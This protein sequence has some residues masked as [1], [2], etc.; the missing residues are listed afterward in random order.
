MIQ[1]LHSIW[2]YS[3]LQIGRYYYWIDRIEG[4]E[5]NEHYNYDNLHCYHLGKFVGVCKVHHND[6]P[7]FIM[8]NE[9]NSLA[10]TIWDLYSNRPRYI[11]DAME[12][13]SV[14]GVDDFISRQPE[15]L[16]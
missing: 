4:G 3:E 1:K 6:V 16:Y 13:Y 7:V 15:G 2:D 10:D 8:N 12:V 11:Y 14:L 5:Y 9:Q